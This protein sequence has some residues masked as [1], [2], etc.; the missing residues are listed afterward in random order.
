VSI[1]STNNTAYGHDGNT[2]LSVHFTLSSVTVP[3][4]SMTS[5]KVLPSHEFYRQLVSDR[6]S[7]LHI[8]ELFETLRSIDL[9]LSVLLRSSSP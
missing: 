8:Y 9:A 5:I 4:G 3:V 2:F 7:R 1:I 6:D